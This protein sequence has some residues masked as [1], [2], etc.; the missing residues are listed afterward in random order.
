MRTTPFVAL[1]VSLLLGCEPE[2]R[3]VGNAPKAAPAPV[4]TPPPPTPEESKPRSILGERTADIR[5]VQSEREK[6]GVAT[7][8]KIVSKDP[9]R[10][11]GNAYVS[12][13]GQASIFKIKQAMDVFKTVNERYPNDTKEFM[14]KVI[15]ENNI[16][17]PRLP[18]Y[19]EYAYDAESHQ[20][21][22][23][24]YPARKEARERELDR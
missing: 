9:I 15:Q 21:V 19:Q 5:D 20:L 12:I 7:A 22:I 14:E 2:P 23:M 8:P 11:M 17:L 13:V 3:T 6:G 24:E 16:A 1:L 10:I 4:V 18:Y